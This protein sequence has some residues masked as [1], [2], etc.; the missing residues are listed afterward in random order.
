MNKSTLKKVITENLRIQ[1]AGADRI[2]YIDATNALDDIGARQSHVI[3]ARRG[4]GKTLLL[5][6]SAEKLS[7]GN[8]AVYLNCE[9]YKNH[10]FPNIIIE[11]LDGA[12]NEIEQKISG[13]SNLFGKGKKAKKIIH[14]IRQRL[15]DLKERQDEIQEQI[16]EVSQHEESIKSSIEVQGLDIL[17]SGIDA[18]DNFKT[19]TE[20]TYKNFDKKIE[21][22]NNELPNLKNKLREFF[23]LSPDIKN[24]YLQVDDFYHLQR[25]MQPYVMDYIHRFCKNLPIYFKIATL[26][27]ASTL[28]I[29]NNGQPIGAQE[30]HD[31]QPIQIDFTFE[32]FKRTEDQVKRIFYKYGELGGGNKDDIDALFKGD[33]FKRL[34]LAGGGVP[35]DCLSLFLE[36]LDNVTRSGD[37]RIS[38][39]DIR[40]LSLSNHE[41]IMRDLKE[42][43]Q[44]D[45]IDPIM[46][47]IYAIREF[48]LSEKN[49]IFVISEKLLQDNE[50]IQRLIYRLLDYKII[51]IVKTAFTHK[52]QQGTTFRAFMINIGHYAN[53]RKL[54]GKMNE[55]DLAALDAKEK[56]RSAPVLTEERLKDLWRIAPSNPEEKI[57]EDEQPINTC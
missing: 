1:K 49:N 35:R 7:T 12:M 2:E 34:I 11:I 25:D 56:I 31:F 14:D 57:L 40:S 50:N 39:D 3:F 26:R 19:G 54:H 33:A 24:I 16:K 32:D 55:I 43:S 8:I 30:R 51:H 41:R 38:K 4:C 22:L 47:G 10:S 23:K 48:C 6:T 17:S 36:V 18:T 15:G 52:S 42:E 13:L 5:E 27:H 37:G 28:Y 20:K 44:K 53:L 9:D 21:K 46:K 45:E 29:E